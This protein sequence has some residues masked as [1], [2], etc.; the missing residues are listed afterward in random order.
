MAGVLAMILAGGEG[1]QLIPLTQNRTQ[2]ALPFAGSYRLVDFVM[3]N[4][5]NSDILKIYVLTQFK[6]QS[7]NLHLRKAWNLTN[8]SGRFIEAIPAQMRLGKRW[9]DGTADAIYQN[10]SFIEVNDPDQVCIFGSDHIYK[11]DVRQMLAQHKDTKADL[12]IAAFKVPL[13]E[14]HRYGVMEIDSKGRVIGFEEKPAKPKALPNEPGYALVSMGNYVFETENLLKELEADSKRPGSSHDFGRDIIPAMLNRFNVHAYL[15]TDN[16]IPGEAG[17]GYWRE[18]R[19][20]D[21]YWSIHMDL[22]EENP[23]FSLY[24]RQ[25]T[26]HTYYPPLPP[27]TFKD[28]DGNKVKVCSSMIS[29]GCY[30]LGSR[31]NRTVMGFRCH[32]RPNSHISESVLLGNVKVG[33]GCRIHK[34]IIDKNAE[35]AP[36]TVIGEDPAEDKARF[37]ISKGGVVIIPKGARIGFDD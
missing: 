4:F 17:S 37:T 36:G 21:D 26:M 28:A 35:I 16:Q 9:Y 20:L 1:S 13:E 33:E 32:I 11:M 14:A 25:W 24:N 19:D 29:A 30:I 23:D 8:I 15:Y 34:A 3:N 5:L 31:V 27:A 2:P 22:L 12:T 18:V 7:L 6:S 10:T